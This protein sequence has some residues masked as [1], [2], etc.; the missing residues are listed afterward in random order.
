MLTSTFYYIYD[1]LF[2]VDFLFVPCQTVMLLF[3]MQMLSET[4]SAFLANV[5]VTNQMVT[6][7]FAFICIFIFAPLLPLLL[8]LIPG[9]KNKKNYV[10]LIQNLTI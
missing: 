1:S 3:F 10:W 7:N 8:G 4:T 2:F 5:L 9:L 6:D